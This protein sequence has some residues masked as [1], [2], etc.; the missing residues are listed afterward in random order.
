[1]KKT[2]ICPKCNSSEVYTN[3][4]KTHREDRSLLVIA[5]WTDATVEVY[6]C[7]DCGF[8]E[9][10]IHSKDLLNEKTIEKIRSTWTK[11]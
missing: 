8:L 10:H 6:A 9:E 4:K 2:G 5:P 3:S 7:L 11:V 1:M